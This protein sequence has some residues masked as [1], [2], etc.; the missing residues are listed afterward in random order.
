M[1]P[2]DKPEDTESDDKETGADLD[3]ALPFDEGDQERKRKH[4]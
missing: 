1:T 3:L 2:V 4:H